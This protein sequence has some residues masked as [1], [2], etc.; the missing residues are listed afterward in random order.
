MVIMKLAFKLTELLV[1]QD[2]E[3]GRCANNELVDESSIAPRGEH[4]LV[5]PAPRSCNIEKTN[6]NLTSEVK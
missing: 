1:V 6:Q 3:Q 2:I 5:P 4:I